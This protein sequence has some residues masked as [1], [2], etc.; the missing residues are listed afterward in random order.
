MRERRERC[1][2]RSGAGAPGTP[3]SASLQEGLDVY[4]RDEWHLRDERERGVPHLR[5]KGIF[6]D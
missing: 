1:C 6:V 2:F 4:F 3:H 5:S